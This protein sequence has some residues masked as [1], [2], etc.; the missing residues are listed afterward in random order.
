MEQWERDML[1]AKLQAIDDGVRAATARYNAGYALDPAAAHLHSSQ[2]RPND[3]VLEGIL[4][5]AR[6]ERARILARLEE[7]AW[8]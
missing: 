8:T 1:E 6:R 4:A 3:V 7:G 5:A 2:K